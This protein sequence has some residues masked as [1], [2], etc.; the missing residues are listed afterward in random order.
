MPDG[1]L[2]L[3][4][5]QINICLGLYESE[6]LAASEMT[7][8]Q[9]FLLN[10]IFSMDSSCVCSTELCERVGFTRS[11][12]SRTLKELRKNGYVKMK[13]D[14]DDN[15]K[16]HIVLTP[17]AHAA[18]GIVKDYIENLNDCLVQEIPEHRLEGIESALRT[19]LDNIQ[20]KIPTILA[21]AELADLRGVDILA[22]NAFET[23][24]RLQ[25]RCRHHTDFY[26]AGGDSGAFGSLCDRQPD[27]QRH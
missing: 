16:K 26:G 8:A 3:T 27:R 19:I 21:G 10:E 22:E 7:F 17:K 9:A 13:M 2:L 5:R 12:I 18:E 14:K 20:Q 25:K 15:R 1:N 23:N 11:S 4:L 24:W 6:K